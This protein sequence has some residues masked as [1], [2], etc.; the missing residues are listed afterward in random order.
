MWK[1]MRCSCVLMVVTFVLTSGASAQEERVQDDESK[2]VRWGFYIGG[3][4][5][6]AFPL[7]WSKEFDREAGKIGTERANSAAVVEFA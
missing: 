5:L 7:G 2:F 1:L 4:G 3:G 6:A